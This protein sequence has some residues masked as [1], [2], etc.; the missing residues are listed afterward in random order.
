MIEGTWVYL[1]AFQTSGPPKATS[2]E[3]YLRNTY[4]DW[5]Q[6]SWQQGLTSAV[7]QVTTNRIH[8]WCVLQTQG[9]YP[10]KASADGE[11]LHGKV[12]SRPRG[13]GGP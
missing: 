2:W 9:R 6:Q 5:S 3:V 8:H 13:P 1:D 4:H 12:N 11:T 10:F 7:F